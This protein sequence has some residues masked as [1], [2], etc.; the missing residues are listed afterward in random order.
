M[1]RLFRHLKLA[2]LLRRHFENFWLILLLRT[3]IVKLP[4]FSYCIRKDDK[5]FSMLARPTTSSVGD[6][7]VLREVLV[8]E[9]YRD[10]CT[11][12]KTKNIRMVDI[13]ANI[14]AFTVWANAVFGVREAFCF[15][16]V[17]D[18]FRL[19]DFNL[20]QNGCAN[21]KI[22]ECAVGGRTRTEKIFTNKNRSATTDI[23]S[24]D[25]STDA[26]TIPV[27]SFEEWLRQVEGNFDLLKMDCEGAEWEIIR[28]TAAQ[29]FERFQIIVA[30]VHPDPE[31]TQEIPEFKPAMEKFG[32]QT[33]RW[34]NKSNGLYI[35]SRNAPKS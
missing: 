9:V 18:S 5:N 16:P 10:V 4:Y 20:C 24:G 22:F 34:D 33:L 8:E 2:I 12:L 6:I 15:E 32:F 19:L 27:I 11:T 25:H 29:H 35:G 1:Q 31:K 23:Y 26:K 21:A 28:N 14:G 30:E 3:G 13:G 7:F 17:P